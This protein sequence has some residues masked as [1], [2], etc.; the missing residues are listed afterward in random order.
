MSNSVCTSCGAPL[1]PDGMFCPSCGASVSAGSSP[2]PPAPPPPPPP[3]YQQPAYQQPV[4]QQ[5]AYRAPTAAAATAP[6]LSTGSYIGM[7]LI[8]YIPL[9]GF[10]M[11]LV[12][13]FG[14]T[15]NPN[16][17]NYARAV[18]IISIIVSALTILITIIAGGAMAALMSELSYY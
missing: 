7:M 10:I 11:L 14:S 18:L 4:Y 9:V 8:A 12:W 16:K 6:V 1:D 3:Q 2:M 5:P 17:K 15:E 13:A